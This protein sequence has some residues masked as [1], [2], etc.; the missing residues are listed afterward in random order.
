MSKRQGKVGAVGQ[1]KS[2]W[3]RIC[4]CWQ[5]Y[6]FLIPTLVYFIIFCYG[7]MYGV[8]IAFRDFSPRK[9]ITGSEWVGLEY[10]QRFFDSYYF[11]ELI[12]NTLAISLYSLVVGFILP[13][14][15]ALLINELT[16]KKFKSVFQTVTYAPYFISTVVFC[17][18]LGVFLNQPNGLINQLIVFLGGEQVDFMTS[19][20]LFADVFVWSG[21]WQG[22]GWSS[23][24]YTAALAGVDEELH[25]AARIDGASRLQRIWHI[26]LP[27]LR[28]TIVTLLI[29]SCGSILSVGYEKVFL[30]QNNLNISTSEVISTYVYK[31]G[32]VQ[33]QYSF[34]TAVGLF[35]SV[36][37]FVILVVVNAV[38]KRIGETSLW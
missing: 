3:K 1:K 26:N 36:I 16:H 9:G 24:I 19:S 8:Q 2:L 7:P 14:L 25:E 37:N 13:I 6:V 20:S 28:P 23:I 18:M 15:L 29:L 33:A 22:T 10:F 21:A 31:T 34:S 12:R 17:G 38:A 5:L 27:H 11:G 32:L 4:S 30:M 35:N